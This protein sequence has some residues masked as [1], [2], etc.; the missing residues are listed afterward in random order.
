MPG[1]SDVV[2]TRR[3]DTQAIAAAPA[4]VGGFRW[5]ICALLFLAT[6]V[7]YLDRQVL[8]ILAAPLQRELDWSE[9]D[10]GWITTAFTGAYA[11]GQL[12]VGSLMDLLGTRMGLSLAV[13]FWSMA[14]MGHALARSALGFGV[15]RIALGLIEASSRT[16]SRVAPSRPWSALAASPAQPAA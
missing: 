12:I 4:R 8:G 13:V 9:S 14:A 15:A 7:N 1:R 5:I 3:S 10:Y 2:E 11:A 16:C 6:T